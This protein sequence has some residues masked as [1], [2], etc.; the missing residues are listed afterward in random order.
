MQADMTG[1]VLFK[2]EGNIS[3]LLVKLI[4]NHMSNSHT[5]RVANIVSVGLCKALYGTL[6]LVLHFL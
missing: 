4:L 1:A 5:W 6:Q 2:L 3:E